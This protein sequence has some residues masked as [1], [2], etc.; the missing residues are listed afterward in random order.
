MLR[1]SREPVSEM[2]GV[3]IYS[4]LPANSEYSTA[5]LAGC[6]LC[7][8]PRFNTALKKVLALRRKPLKPKIRNLWLKDRM[9]NYYVH[10]LN[11]LKH[12]QTSQVSKIT[13]ILA[14]LSF[15]SNLTCR[16]MYHFN[17]QPPTGCITE[18]GTRNR[19]QR[20]GNQRIYAGFSY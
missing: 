20:W 15:S 12:H 3:R 7:I 19:W 13:A 5:P 8:R 1:V 17:S 2:R 14:F 16:T 10:V 11:L 6:A 18:R 9:F 4:T